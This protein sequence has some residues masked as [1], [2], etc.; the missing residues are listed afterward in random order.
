[1]DR[2]PKEVLVGRY[3]PGQRVAQIVVLMKDSKGALAEVAG[4]MAGAGVDI[5][6]SASS[7]SSRSQTAVY[8]ALV[9]LEDNAVTIEEL[10][11]RMKA[12]R[13]VID[14]EGVS[15][16][17][18]AILDQLTFPMTWAGQRS[19]L[20]N[21]EALSGML[22][23]IRGIFGTGGDMILFEQGRT[24]GKTLATQLVSDVGEAFARKN[25]GYGL[26]LISATGWG[27]PEVTDFDAE[28]NYAV[29]RVRDSFECDGQRSSE[30]CSH[31][32]RGFLVG[33][34]LALTG[35]NLD[36]RETKCVARGED[37]CEFTLVKRESR[38]MQLYPVGERAR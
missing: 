38:P 37:C 31:F 10:V 24:Y 3:I 28:F 21:H 7:S 4:I 23:S 14:A 6:Q 2:F 34:L 5:K 29:I 33:G 1:M 8:N 11:K 35:R 13:F 22:E 17:E 30:P 16:V 27:V 20:L 18:G 32:M 12:S 25:F 15:G 36:C 19:V 26:K 9:V